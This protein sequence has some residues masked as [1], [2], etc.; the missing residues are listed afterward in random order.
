MNTKNNEAPGAPGMEPKWT[1]SSK[2]GI[3]K[4]LNPASQVAFTLSHG[5]LNEVYYPREDIACI[6]DMEL[7]VTDGDGLFY[8]EK[9]DTQHVTKMVETGIP[10]YQIKNTS[11]KG[12]FEIEKEILTDPYRDTILQHIRFKQKK[13]NKT[14]KLYALLAPHINNQG[15]NNTGWIGEYKG[16]PML[17][18]QNGDITLAL[19]CSSDLLKRSV[20]YV[21]TS[22]GWTDIHRHKE[23]K[24]DYPQ[25]HNGNIALTAEIDISESHD[26]VLALSFG[27]NVAEAANHARSS[28]LDGFESAKAEYVTEWSDWQKTLKTVPAKNAKISAAVLRI[29]EAN[30]FPGGIIASLSI[31]WGESKND[32]DESGYHL[33]WPRDLAESS[34]GFLALEA[35]DDV[36]RILNFLM[37]TQNAD[38]SWPQN[39]WLEGEPNWKGIQ[40]DQVALPIIEVH[41]A[42]ERKAID[43][44]RMSRYWPLT[45]KALS[46][47]L[48][49]GAYTRQ[50]R[51]EE[52]EGYTPYTLATEIAALLAGAALA[53]IN[54]EEGLAQFC[55]ETADNWNEAIEKQLY[56]E[57]TQLAKNHNIEGYYIR[58]NPFKDIAAQDLGE[59]TINL[60]NH[61]NGEGI[62]KLTDLISVDALALVRFGLRAADDPKILNTLKVIDAL[63]KV[64]TPNGPCW[65][66][67]NND[68]Y[69][70][71]ANGDPYDGTGIGRA[72]PLLTGERAHYEIAAGNIK[73]AKNLLKAMDNFSN[74]GLIPEQIWDSEDIPEKR[75]FLGKH[76]GA[77]MPL[78]WANAEYLKLCASIGEKKIFEMPSF[79]E[80]RYIKN[81]TRCDFKIWRFDNPLARFSDKKYLRIEMQAMA[82]V[83]W[84]DDGWK[85]EH[86]VSAIDTGIGIFVAD[87]NEMNAK[88]DKIEFTFYWEKA[89]KWEDKR[90]AVDVVH[91]RFTER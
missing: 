43:V 3:G 82:D 17:F 12:G 81:K 11:L 38:G 10:A 44:A 65:H 58:I 40:M 47:I 16:V 53:E 74:H 34:G 61:K 13:K 80:D 50:D 86:T 15:R 20:G 23:M 35:D 39:M 7:L 84:S 87:I 83:V 55:R 30:S 19:A 33:V 85:S 25:A 78:T 67:Y 63:L 68:G 8:E 45:K 28:L 1:S 21:G 14:Y 76:T 4:S 88:T 37:S 42:Y 59:R 52:E 91:S 6:R 57:G 32:R 27:R 90:Y 2:S 60:K 29:H 69:G 77:A 73:K 54:G 70:E 89:N 36:S 26:F 24:W 71:H 49:N 72:W 18:A 62:V 9:R 41:K 56:V 79:T 46:F 22:D 64:D 51:W 75:L 5:I 31:P 66:R 48:K